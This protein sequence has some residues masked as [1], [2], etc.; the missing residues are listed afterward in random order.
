MSNVFI[1]Y[2]RGDS[3]AT[4]GRIRDRLVQEFGRRGIFVDVDDIPHGQDFVKVLSDKVAQCRVLLAVIGPE[5]GNARDEQGRRRIERPDDFVGI[6]IG[7]ALARQDMAVIPVLIDGARMPTADELPDPLKPLTRRNAIELRNTQFGSDAERL[8][9]AIRAA[10]PK[11]RGAT[12][13]KLVL[14]VLAIIAAA[15]A[16]IFWPMLDP[17]AQRGAPLPSDPSTSSEVERVKFD[18]TWRIEFNGNEFCTQTRR[19]VEHWPINEGVMIASGGG[20]GTVSPAGELRVRWPNPRNPGR[21]YSLTA[22]L[23]GDA[24][25]GAFQ[26]EGRSCAGSLTLLRSPPAERP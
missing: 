18:G 1:S 25:K 12:A 15:A 22:K 24:G 4:A 3:I 11:A 9:R 10:L 13:L 6:E 2:R 20:R 5:W 7:S 14:P 17:W 26:I 19:L 21:I 16:V 8:I 23:E